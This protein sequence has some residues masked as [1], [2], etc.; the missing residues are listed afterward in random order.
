MNEKFREPEV[1]CHPHKQWRRQGQFSQ[2]R[3]HRCLP[4]LVDCFRSP[5]QHL[6][7]TKVVGIAV[8]IAFAA[9]IHVGDTEIKFREKI[10]TVVD[11]LKIALKATF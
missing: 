2:Q 3:H 5:M 9:A 6:Q 11:I 7:P 4:L 10:F 1:L 8:A